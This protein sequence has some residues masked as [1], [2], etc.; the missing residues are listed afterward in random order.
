MAVAG[1]A[2]FALFRACRQH[3]PAFGPAIPGGGYSMSKTQGRSVVSIEPASPA[4]LAPFGRL[5]A[6]D[7]ATRNV[8]PFY[9]GAVVTSRPVEYDCEGPTELSLARIQPRAP[10]VRFLERHFLHTQAFL[11]LGSKPFVL[12]M[13]PPAPAPELASLRAFLFDGSAGFALHR[14][15]WH[16]FPFALHA[17]TDIVVVLSAQTVRDL[18]NTAADSLDASGPDLEK[19]DLA[20]R[21]AALPMVDLAGAAPPA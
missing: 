7:E 9:D 1:L 18:R 17:D 14:G 6:H 21:H 19:I 10:Q 2:A 11:P 8:A 5:L 20:A 3:G 4:A 15:T 12:V 13:A 16:E